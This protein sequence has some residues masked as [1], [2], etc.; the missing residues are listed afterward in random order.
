M[1]DDQGKRLAALRSRVPNIVLLALY[2][3]AAVAGACHFCSAVIF[4]LEL[5][6]LSDLGIPDQRVDPER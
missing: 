5:C 2:G 4:Q 1:I 3:V 6:C